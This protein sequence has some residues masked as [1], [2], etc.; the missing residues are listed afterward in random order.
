MQS[1]LFAERFYKA[2]E[3]LGSDSAAVRLAGVHALASLADDWVGGR[4]MRANVVEVLALV[5]R[6]DQEG[7]LLAGKTCREPVTHQDIPGRISS[8]DANCGTSSIAKE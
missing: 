2:R 6:H 7:C 4:Q 5:R 3:M 8:S 1:K